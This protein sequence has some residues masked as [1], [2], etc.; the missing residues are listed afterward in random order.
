M[1]DMS[2]LAGSHV[3]ITGGGG[4]I[5]LAVARRL[6]VEGAAIT[7]LDIDADKLG[8]A[9][10]QLAG[11]GAHVTRYVCDVTDAAQV[12]DTVIEIAKTVGPIDRLFNNAGFQGAFAPLH[13]YP[14]DDFAHVMEINVTGAFHM[15]RAVSAQ[16]VAAGHGGAIVNTASMAGVSGP[17]N[18][19]AYGA[20]KAAIIGLTLTAAKDLAPH[21]IRVNAISPGFIGPGYMWER[22]IDKQAAARS[23]YYAADPATAADQMIGSV[24]MRRYG[25]LIEVPGAVAFLLSDDASYM[26]G[27][28]LPISGGGS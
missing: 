11:D 28:N 24:P 10:A 15:L 8:A 13:D 18:M 4:E 9:A 6:A 22:Q 1:P 5:G 23:Q 16:M 21:A 12:D 26:T 2:R 3:L 14:G 25:D 17:P 19:A 27:T 7:L 20:S